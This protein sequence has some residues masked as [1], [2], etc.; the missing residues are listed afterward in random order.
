MTEIIIKKKIQKRIEI[1][2]ACIINK[3]IILSF[4]F[5]SPS[6]FLSLTSLSDQT[7]QRALVQ[8]NPHRKKPGSDVFVMLQMS[9][10]LNRGETPRGQWSL[11]YFWSGPCC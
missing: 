2:T 8:R 5:F 4:S 7:I 1:G 6:V 9:G 10:G 11:L 3:N